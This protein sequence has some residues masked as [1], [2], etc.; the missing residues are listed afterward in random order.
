MRLLFMQKKIAFEFSAGRW[1]R[2]YDLVLKKINNSS[3]LFYTLGLLRNS[4]IDEN[5]FL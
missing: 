2:D 1:E 3:K 4:A 5:N